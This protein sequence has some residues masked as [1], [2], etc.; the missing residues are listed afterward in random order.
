MGLID[1]CSSQYLSQSYLA[2]CRNSEIDGILME[3]VESQRVLV[4]V[5]DD[6]EMLREGADDRNLLLAY[7]RGELQGKAVLFLGYDPYNPDFDLLQLRRMPRPVAGDEFAVARV[8]I[9]MVW[10]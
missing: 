8:G 2:S 3:D 6:Y 4:V 7:L 10:S 5:E 1:I 9:L